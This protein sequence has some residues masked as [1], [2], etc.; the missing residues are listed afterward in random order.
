M[1]LLCVEF[2]KNKMTVLEARR[3]LYEMK[4]D[5]NSEHVEE[6]EEMLWD[7]EVEDAM[8]KARNRRAKSSQ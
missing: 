2:Q 4:E 8:R 5:L 6:I 1:C 7:S 3:A